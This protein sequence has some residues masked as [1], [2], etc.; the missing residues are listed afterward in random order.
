MF[1]FFTLFWHTWTGVKVVCFTICMCLGSVW[2]CAALFGFQTCL[3]SSI[4]L[5]CLT[6][7]LLVS[8]LYFLP[9]SLLYFYLSFSLSLLRSL[10]SASVSLCIAIINPLRTLGRVIRLSIFN[11]HSWWANTHTENRLFMFTRHIGSC[12]HT[13]NTQAGP[14]K[15]ACKLVHATPE[16]QQMKEVVV[17]NIC[18]CSRLCI[19]PLP[20]VQ[21]TQPR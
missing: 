16:G 9:P 10:L 15:L 12:F 13:P 19:S 20:A 17:F 8:L 1:A 4:M 14:E 5:F 7:S 21:V 11:H 18:T 2:V 3:K 6:F